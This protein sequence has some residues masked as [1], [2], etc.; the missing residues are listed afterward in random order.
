VTTHQVEEIQNVLTDVMFINSGRIVFN[1]TME[2][3]ESRYME[4]M[5]NPDQLV[6]ARAI[7]PINERQVFGRTILLFDAADRHQ[8][9]ALGD[10]RTPSLADL[11]VAI[12]GNQ[13]VQAQGVAR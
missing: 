2:D 12:I 1:S 11:F 6:A 3:L 5:V 7:N 9:A 4:L 13:P 8:L 10:V